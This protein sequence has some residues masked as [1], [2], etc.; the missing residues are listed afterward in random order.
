MRPAGRYFELDNDEIELAM[1]I[2][3]RARLEFVAAGRALITAAQE[4][5]IPDHIVA[6]ALCTEALLLAACLHGGTSESFLVMA[7]H[8]L[9]A[10]GDQA[11]PATRAGTQ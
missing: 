7:G 2:G 1:A 9:E 4:T 5:G 11:E 10:T 6:S 3:I 8:A